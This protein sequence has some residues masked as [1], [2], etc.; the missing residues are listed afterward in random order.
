MR[1]RRKGLAEGEKFRWDGRSRRRG[2]ISRG[3]KRRVGK[4][5]VYGA[6]SDAEVRGGIRVFGA[7]VRNVEGE[8]SVRVRTG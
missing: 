8:N 3:A 7:E 1:N 5:A 6:P 2:G 4:E